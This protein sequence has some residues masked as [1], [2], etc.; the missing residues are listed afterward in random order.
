M[1]FIYVIIVI[2]NISCLGL[3]IGMAIFNLFFF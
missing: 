2:Y 3:Q 1:H